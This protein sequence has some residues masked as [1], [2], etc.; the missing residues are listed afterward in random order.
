MTE[1]QDITEKLLKGKIKNTFDVTYE[2]GLLNGKDSVIVQLRINEIV[3]AQAV[4]DPNDIINH[5]MATIKTI[6][7]EPTE[8]EVFTDLYNITNRTS[9][10]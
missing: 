1:L 10:K 7:L 4:A 3:I 6:K 8:D 5:L 9:H 2:R